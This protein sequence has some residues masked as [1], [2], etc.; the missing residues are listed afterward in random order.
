MCA[1]VGRSGSDRRSDRG[2]TERVGE[3]VG[4]TEGVTEGVAE[5]VE[6]RDGKVESEKCDNS[7][8]QCRW[9]HFMVSRLRG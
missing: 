5:G 8:I 6:L 2:V 9:F 1:G 4:V 3:G 7:V